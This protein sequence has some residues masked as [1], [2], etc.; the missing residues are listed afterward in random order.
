MHIK[1]FFILFILCSSSI[2]RGQQKAK[3]FY[4]VNPDT[5]N[6]PVFVRGNLESKKI[7][8]YVQG[9]GADNG[10]DFGRSDYPKWRNTLETK[11]AI[12]YFDQRGLNRS[13]NRIDTSK[14]NQT[15]VLKDIVTISKSLKDK[16][17][18]EIYLFGH[19]NGGVKILD[20]LASL[21][22][23]TSFIKSGIVFNAPITTDF[24]PERYNHYRPLYLKNLAKD[25]IAKNK[26]TAYWQEAFRW[27]VKTDS[28]STPEISRKWNSY[29]DNAYGPKK[30]KIGLSM[31]FNTIISKPYNPIKYMNNK[32]NKYIADKLWY[33]E[34]AL[35][36]KGT[37]TELW[38]KLPKINHNILLI[39][40]QYDAIAV[41]EEQE[42]A[43]KLIRDSEL[44]IIPNS[45]HETYLDQPKEFNDTILSFLELKNSANCSLKVS[46]NQESL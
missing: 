40:G 25:F 45:A 11:V 32:D 38:D 42:E 16:Y 22:E 28:I 6:L 20:C 4:Y 36:D 34:K 5:K 37:Q 1:S 35:W 15:Q 24:S 43:H 29:V 9:G 13:V 17:N 8:L 44:I 23:E 39:T 2:L 10:I 7:L 41:P 46:V 19:S 30:R 33:D 21:D 18:A 14:I 27:M 12:A 26:D 3:D 31:I